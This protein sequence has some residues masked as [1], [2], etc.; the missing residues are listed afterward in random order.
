MRVL[1]LALT[2]L[3][4]SCDKENSDTGEWLQAEVVLTSD[5]NCSRTVLNFEQDSVAVRQITSETSLVY[6]AKE[7]PGQFNITG[8]KVR[9]RVR[10]IKP[11][12]GFA[13][14]T[15]GPSY[16]AIVVQDVQNH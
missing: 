15:I 11:S 6:V 7:F 1:F 9:V 16:P 3:V 14:L 2:F 10:K 5:I 8:N 12:E 4:I 13:C